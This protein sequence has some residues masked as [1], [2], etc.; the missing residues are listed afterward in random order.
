MPGSSFAAGLAAVLVVATVFRFWRLAWG[1]EQ[2]LWFPDEHLWAVRVQSFVPFGWHSFDA[3]LLV[4]PTLYGYLGGLATAVRA[5]CGSIPADT[6]P[7]EI[8]AVFTARA[9]SA[10]AS[11]GTVALVACV[12]RRIASPAVGLTAALFLAVTPLDALQVHYASGDPLLALFAV[13]VLAL[14]LR[15]AARGSVGAAAAAGA[16]VGFATA[17]KY[18][19]LAYG[20]MVVWAILEH[21]WTQ[22]R[23]AHAMLLL[24][25]AVLAAGAAAVLGC[26]PCALHTDDLTKNVTWMRHATAWGRGYLN[27]HLPPTLGWY[28][29]PYLY[30]LV[31]SL[32]WSLGWPLY[33]SALL[34]VVVAV[35]RH[36]RADRLLLAAIVPYFAVVG[37]YRTTFPRYLLPIVPALVLLAARALPA[38]R[39]RAAVVVAVVAVYG[40]TLTGSQVTRFSY[41]QQEQV[42]Q[43][44]A[45][46]VRT[47]SR[48]LVVGVPYFGVSDYFRVVEPFKRAGLRHVWMNDGEWLAKRADVLV[49]PEWYAIGL[50]RDWPGS[51]GATELAAL[52]SDASGYVE[53]MRW[54]TSWY[55]QRPIDVRIDPA[56]AADL[57]QGEIGFRAYV[58]K[59]R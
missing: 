48:P 22:R 15:V 10:V 8:D 19:G 25:S 42:A 11:L 29:Q 50:E 53:A 44:V 14:A 2:G 57:W 45:G 58:R 49:I 39:A 34:G 3:N 27:N 5:A 33:L 1:L 17:T 38:A 18:T 13:V 40:A 55:L 30:Q 16:A 28:G 47:E 4:Y 43:W 41:R 32:P 54:P 31:A 35:R 24:T 12:G 7:A 21:F 37:G 51:A 56:F 26:P 23:P 6:T 46:I 20:T 9:V 36:D 52:R 59:P